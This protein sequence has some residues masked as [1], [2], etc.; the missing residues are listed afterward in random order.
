MVA[1]SGIMSIQAVLLAIVVTG[2]IGAYL[3]LQFFYVDF[4][5]ISGLPEKDGA[6]LI[7]GHLYN[8]G[9]DHASTA[10]A[11]GLDN[12]W[13]VFQIRLGNRRA[14]MLNSFDAAREWIVT[15]QAAT[16]DRPW[17]YTFHGVVSKTSGESLESQVHSQV[18]EM[19]PDNDKSGYYRHE[20]LG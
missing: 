4:A 12:S 1:I 19:C 5:H 15:Q 16:I 17:L 7:S 20:S 9:N 6:S 2:V 14:I 3:Y 18:L 13:G 10:E 8:L 11:W